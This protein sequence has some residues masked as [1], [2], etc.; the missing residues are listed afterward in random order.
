MI[1]YLGFPS[2]HLVAQVGDQKLYG[3]EALEKMSIV[4][5]GTDTHKVFDS[6]VDTGVTTG[7]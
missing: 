5:V 2:N 6:G 4:I 3:A 7:K 1:S